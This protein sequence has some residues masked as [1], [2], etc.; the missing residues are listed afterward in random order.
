MLDRIIFMINLERTQ[1][2]T[3][4]QKKLKSIE[5]A[6]VIKICD[7]FKKRKANKKKKSDSGDEKKCQ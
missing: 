2:F 6:W 3:L 4:F 5:K 7:L 1:T